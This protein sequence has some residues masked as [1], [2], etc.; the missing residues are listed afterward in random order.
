MGTRQHGGTAGPCEPVL[1][2]S[3]IVKKFGGVAA[4]DGVT[5]DLPGPGIHALIGPNGSGKT[6][7][8]NVISGFLRADAGRIT[9]NGVKLT[10]KR[11]ES[12]SRLGVRRTFQHSVTF[13]DLTVLES[14]QIGA[15][16]A[17][18]DRN[19]ILLDKH[20]V[21][22][23]LTLCGLTEVAHQQTRQLS[24]GQGRLL[25]IALAL[26]ANCTLLLLDEPAA[27]LND[28][29]AAQVA[30]VMRNLADLN[31]D[32]LVIDHN[33]GFVF[34]VASHIIVLDQGR[35][36]AEGNPD[37][38]RNNDSVVRSYLGTGTVA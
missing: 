12:I 29:E 4:L 2:V 5:F 35:L 15:V 19:K 38:I 3:G 36:L 10:G 32:Q 6:T 18:M 37:E 28:D 23:L 20:D 7:M 30:E 1:S 11:P 21:D 25:G 27:G 31:I 16:H 8:V 24:F 26:T 13:R 14:L 9:V 17:K 34:T 33:M 22:P